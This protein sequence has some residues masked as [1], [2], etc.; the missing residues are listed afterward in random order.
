MV[1]L[2]YDEMENSQL[3]T[4][5]RAVLTHLSPGHGEAN[6]NNHTAL[7]GTGKY[8]AYTITNKAQ[9]LLEMVKD[10]A[11]GIFTILTITLE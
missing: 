4:D 1:P 2:Q 8:C 3:P 6:V 11:S 5:L 10:Y 9:L 7:M